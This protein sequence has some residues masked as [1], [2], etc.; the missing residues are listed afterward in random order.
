MSAVVHGAWSLQAPLVDVLRVAMLHGALLCAGMTGIIVASLWHDPMVWVRSSP[1]DVQA[2][3]GP[4]SAESQRR[5][6]AWAGL[7]LLVLLGVFGSLCAAV[8]A[9]VAGDGFPVFAL[10]LASFIAFQCFNLFDALV[11]DLGLVVFKPRWAFPPGTAHLR[12]FT[13]VRWHV[14][15]YVKGLFG[16]AVFAAL[17]VAAAFPVWLTGR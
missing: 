16:G 12:G 9:L 8:F 4:P 1:P 15:N 5:R 7:T 10:F 3:V 6:R 2:A 11:I 14:G 17:V 13:D